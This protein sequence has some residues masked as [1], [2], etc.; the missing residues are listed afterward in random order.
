MTDP[1]TQILIQTIFTV[2]LWLLALII[3]LL[4]LYMVIRLGI[5]HGM[6]SYARQL[7]ED[8]GKQRYLGK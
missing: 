5:T 3:S 6:L 1:E 8:K 2:A 7:D 4:L